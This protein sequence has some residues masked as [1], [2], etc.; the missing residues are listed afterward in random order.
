[1]TIE[2]KQSDPDNASK[3]EAVAIAGLV[4][5]GLMSGSAASNYHPYVFYQWLR[6]AVFLGAGFGAWR[7][8]VRSWW[9]A[10]LLLGLLSILFNP[11]SPFRLSR[12]QWQPYDV[13]GAI[14]CFAMAALLAVVSFRK[15]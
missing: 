12:Y 9:L 5:A 2:A 13:A 3:L 7:F 10:T 11:F 6:W 8:G 1:M 4:V 14:V 15:T